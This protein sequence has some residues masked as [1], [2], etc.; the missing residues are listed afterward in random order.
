[1]KWKIVV[2]SAIISIIVIALMVF[3]FNLSTELGIALSSITSASPFILY[4]LDYYQKARINLSIENAQFVEKTI[5]EKLSG[6][7]LKVEIVNKGKKI[8]LN[9]VAVFRIKDKHEKAPNTM[10][11][12]FES[13]NCDNKVSITEESFKQHSYAWNTIDNTTCNGKEL[14]QNDR[15]CI[16]FPVETF[17]GIMVSTGRSSYSS[18]YEC[19]IKLNECSYFVEV[20]LKGE[21]LEK[22]TYIKKQTFNLSVPKSALK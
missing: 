14:R 12:R 13:T 8:C 2:P 4:G 18:S 16:L 20:E 5:D 9:C 19:L 3:Y 11:V 22:N 7:Q 17:G 21:D 6:Y 15:Y 1:M 10:Q